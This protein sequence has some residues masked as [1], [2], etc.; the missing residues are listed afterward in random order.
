MPT[1]RRD[2]ADAFLRDPDGGPI[3]F[4]GSLDDE[5]VED[6]LIAATTGEDA[7]EDL[8]NQEVPEDH[9]GPFVTTRASVEMA[10]GVDES[11]PEDAEVAALP[12][13]MRFRI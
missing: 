4:S 11:N 9:G 10:D 13:V 6:F 1:Q 5:L 12:T 7:G 3:P 2:D 8:R